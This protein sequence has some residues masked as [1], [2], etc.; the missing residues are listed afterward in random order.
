M[1]TNIFLLPKDKNAD[2]DFLPCVKTV[3]MTLLYGKISL[4]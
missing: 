4:N 2:Y 1:S 3:T